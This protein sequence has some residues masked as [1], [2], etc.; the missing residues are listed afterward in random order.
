MATDNEIDDKIEAAYESTREHYRENPHRTV[1]VQVWAD[2][3]EGIAD[4]VRYL[5]T[6]PGVRT[7]ASCEGTPKYKPY[8]MA[9]WPEEIEP[10]LREEFEV[11]TL[12]TCWGYIRRRGR[13]R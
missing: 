10:R 7:D 8:V 4:L 11:E 12:G 6:I 13:T 5:N 1:P 3:D 2:I 9:R